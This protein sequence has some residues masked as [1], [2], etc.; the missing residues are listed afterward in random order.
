MSIYDH[1][2]TMEKLDYYVYNHPSGAWGY[3]EDQRGRPYRPVLQQNREEF[4][5]F[6]LLLSKVRVTSTIMQI[7]IGMTGGAHFALRQLF[8]RVVSLDID[9]ENIEIIHPIPRLKKA[10]GI[11]FITDLRLTTDEENSQPITGCE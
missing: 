4:S 6:L 2:A 5:E 9:P 8:D 7:G 11:P 10:V 1:A 3:H